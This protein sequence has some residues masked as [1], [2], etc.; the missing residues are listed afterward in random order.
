MLPEAEDVP[1]RDGVGG[2]CAAIALETDIADGLWM[3]DQ[4]DQGRGLATWARGRV[5]LGMQRRI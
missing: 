5:S 2:I 4:H 1:A 3:E